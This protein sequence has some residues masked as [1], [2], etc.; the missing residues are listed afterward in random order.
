MRFLL[1][2]ILL[3]FSVESFSTEYVNASY[4]KQT[5]SKCRD[6][7]PRSR[8]DYNE[9]LRKAKGV[10]L[11]KWASRN[12]AAVMNIYSKDESFL[13]KDI[14]NY[15]IDPKVSVEC[16]GRSFTLLLKAQVAVGAIN[17]L[18]IQEAPREEQNM[19][20][21]F[22][23][24]EV[25]SI[26]QFDTK[27]S[28]VQKT[29]R[30]ASSDESFTVTGESASSN[31]VSSST[32]L[33]QS[34]G[35]SL[36][37]SAEIEWVASRASGLDMVTNEIFNSYF[38]SP[39][40]LDQVAQSSDGMLL[41]ELIDS[42]CCSVEP[43]KRALNSIRNGLSKFNKEYPDYKINLLTIVTMDIN[44][45]YVDNS[46]GMQIVN[47]TVQGSVSK[48]EGPFWKSV[49]SV[50]PTQMAGSGID[51]IAASTNAMNSAAEKA[52]LE[53]VTQLTARNLK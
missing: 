44:S 31:G 13:M 1:I 12:S 30:K 42:F 40:D 22:I 36:I 16:E 26:K 6:G 8:D 50:R 19:A 53:I 33:T 43:D 9:A 4:T 20:I 51:S 35:N 18:L 2:S 38:I 41:N 24:R 15:I 46:T 34:G 49:A 32:T 11:K 37:K 5:K 23:A 27:R 47:V 21:L 39:I 10:A 45:S 52:A 3:F 17:Q 14:D 28:D 29:T 48:K 25:K 7:Q